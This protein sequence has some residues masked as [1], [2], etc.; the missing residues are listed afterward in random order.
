MLSGEEPYTIGVYRCE[1]TDPIRF[2]RNVEGPP[3][4]EMV[5]IIPDAIRPALQRLRAV[6]D[7]QVD[8]VL[9]DKILA[10]CNKE[11]RGFGLVFGALGKEDVEESTSRDSGVD[12]IH[13]QS[14]DHIKFDSLFDPPL[15][16]H[17]APRDNA[18]ARAEGE[19][20]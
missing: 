9:L 12:E 11:T 19:K 3:R 10:K 16:V 2:F 7:E 18:P 15:D 13:P 20:S 8:E 17:D 1:P 6:R 4:S 14:R 5:L